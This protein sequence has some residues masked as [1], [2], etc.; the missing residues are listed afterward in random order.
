MNAKSTESS[1][2]DLGALQRSASTPPAKRRRGMSGLMVWLLVLGLLG[3]AYVVLRPLLFPPKDVRVTRA[4]RLDGNEASQVSRA[5]YVDAPGW[6]EA[7]PYPVS[8][9]PFV[10]GV[11]E[12]LHVLEGTAVEVG[13]TVLATLRNPDIENAVDTAKARVATARE[14]VQSAAV[15]LKVAT[16]ILEQRLP[17]RERLASLEG[18][19]KAAEAEL[20]A[21]KAKQREKERAIETAKVDVRAQRT[22]TARGKGAPVALARAEAAL[23]EVEEHALEMEHQTERAQAAAHRIRDLM[24]LAQE[25]INDPRAL[26]GE[27]NSRRAVLGLRRAEL[28]QAEVDLSVA[29]KNASYLSV[30]APMTGVV[31]RLECAPGATVGPMGEF[32]GEAEAG[33]SGGLNR[34]TGSICSVYDANSMQ[35]RVDVPLAE[36]GAIDVGT[37]A[38]ITVRAVAGRTFDGIVTRRVHE[39]DINKNTLQVKVRVEKPDG[40][41]RPEML[42]SARFLIPPSARKGTTKPTKHVTTDGAVFRIPKEAVRDGAVYV[43]DPRH[44]GR[45]RKVGIELVHEHDGMAHVRGALTRSS[46]IILD[47]VADGDAV[48]T[49]GAN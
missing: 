18:D 43:Y 24:K 19:L 44:G 9:R 35:A 31:L 47:A 1:H 2:V 5:T 7:D 6:M 8:V 4:E 17:L 3:A 46:Q 25:G 22:L 45:A 23:R 30:K 36:V 37:K 32:K 15:D 28:H 27:V 12:T 26:Q 41:L 39:A 13:N 14:R 34:M 11:V 16:S 48:R 38:K 40:L 33:S 29:Q 21:A 20:E 49:A 42:C 10:S